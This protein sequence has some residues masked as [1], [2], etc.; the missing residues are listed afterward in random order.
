M[1]QKK[2][3]D[4]AFKKNTLNFFLYLTNFATVIAFYSVYCSYNDYVWHRD[5]PD[6]WWTNYPTTEKKFLKHGLYRLLFFVLP[7]LTL[8]AFIIDPQAKKKAKKND[9]LFLMENKWIQWWDNILLELVKQD[10]R[11]Q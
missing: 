2:Q 5:N 11:E 4:V 3:R 1:L 9:N 10:E 6:K 8:N 7:P